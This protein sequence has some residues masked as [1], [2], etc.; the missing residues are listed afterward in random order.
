[1]KKF[2][3]AACILA[4]SCASAFSQD[5]DHLNCGMYHNQEQMLDVNPERRAR[6]ARTTADLE[7]FT[8]NYQEADR[9]LP[10]KIIPVVFHIIH[11]NGAENIPDANV[12][13]A[14]EILNRDYRKQN[15]DTSTIVSA[16][17]SIAADCAIEFRLACYDPD[18]NCTTGI[19]R[20]VSDLTNVGD[21][22]VKDLIHWPRDMY[23]NIYVCAAANGAAG[24][25]YLP[26]SV[27]GN[28]GETT[29]GIVIQD[30]Y[31]S[32]LSPSNVTKSR[33][34]THE[35]GHYLN[36]NHTWGYSND[37]AVATNCNMDDQVDDTPNTIGWT[38]CN[39]N[40]A[41]CG[42]VIDNVQN[43]M[44]YSYCS[45]MFTNGQRDRMRATLA[46]QV[47]GR[48]NLSSSA[49]LI[50]TGVTN[51]PLCLADFTTDLY[52]ICVGDTVHFTDISYH[53]VTNWNW[54]FGDGTVLTG[55]D[56]TIYQ[57]PAHVYELA[58]TYTVTLT[59]TSPNGSLTKAYSNLI[60][61]LNSGNSLPPFAEGFENGFST[62]TWNLYNQNNNDTW[63]ITPSAHYSG[64]K[65]LK[66]RNYN[67]AI[68]DDTD[69]IASNTFDMSAMD[70]VKLSYKWAYANRLVGTDDRLRISLSGDCGNTWLLKRLRKGLTNLVTAPATNSQFTPADVT[71]WGSETLTIADQNIMT[72]NFR[73]KFEFVSKGGNNIF[74]DDINIASVDSLGNHYV[75]S[76]DENELTS[77]IFAVAY[78][79][80]SQ[81]SMVL[82]VEM[83]Q[84]ERT[85]VILYNSRGQY[86]QN[87]YSGN[88]AAG[89]HRF[90]I[91][92]QPRGLYTAVVKTSNG[93]VTKKIVFE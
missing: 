29:D 43:Y 22:Q 9:S 53:G 82:E 7:E 4:L 42:N 81:S 54:N 83:M 37:P 39:L 23:L 21:D 46:S 75:L 51:P 50:A 11:N 18:G 41:S 2:Y 32:D 16:F 33:A 76:I 86:I 92:H 5:H 88:M 13:R 91:E 44:E 77:G 15:A 69:Y 78:P 36:L 89:Q 68:L 25:A 65:C 70:T 45:R 14:I 93:L 3:L 57:S 55:T 27:D 56:A 8:R 66:L 67:S 61:V 28:W 30:D 17:Q 1:M 34:L 12:H 79:N 52:S 10:L 90:N 64:T 35:V 71:Q 40:G 59:V 38:S 74:L 24:Y 58:G 48:N 80:P 73:V 20:I 84:N 85:E 31:V 47:A 87:I 63:E 60:T 62:A 72:S 19:N 26:G 6:A 49:N